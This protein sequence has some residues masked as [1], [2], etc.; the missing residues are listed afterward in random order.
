MRFCG[1]CGAPT[2]SIQPDASPKDAWTVG[3]GENAQVKIEHPSISRLHL[4]V[5]YTSDAEVLAITDLGT[6]N[7]TY[8]RSVRVSS[9]HVRL[10]DVIQLG[11][12][13][14]PVRNLLQSARSTAA[15]GTRTLT[16]GRDQGDIR[17]DLSVVSGRHAELRLAPG[18]LEIRD[19]GSSN[20]TYVD[21]IRVS[22]W[23]LVGANA[24]LHL[25]SFRVPPAQIERW[26]EQFTPAAGQQGVSNVSVALTKTTT[27]G[28]DPAS[29]VLI[30]HP[31]ISW[32]HARID[33]RGKTVNIVD[34]RSSNGV[35][36][37]G[38]RVT[39]ATISVGDAVR[40]GPVPISLQPDALVVPKAYRGEVRVDARGVTRQLESGAFAGQIILDDVSLTIFPGEMV[41]LMGPSGAGKT[42]LLEVLTGQRPPS[43]GTV[44]VNGLDLH[45]QRHTLADRIGYVPQEDVMHR[46][47]TVFEVLH[48]AARLRLPSDLP[49]SALREH[50]E[51]LIDRMG[52][53][54][55]RDTLIGGESV[56]GVSGGQRKRV[57]IALELL[58]EPPLL[59]LDEP[60]SGLDATS[61][62]EVLRVLRSLADEGKTIIM[63]I[64]QPRVEAFRMVDMLI[65]L[66]KGGKLAYFGPAVPGAVD[67][68]L[69]RSGNPHKADSNPADYA[70]DALDSIGAGTNQR[71]PD[72]KMEYRLSDQYREYVVTRADSQSH[73]A[74]HDAR[75]RRRTPF[76]Q[77]LTLVHRTL[78]RKSRESTALIVQALQP[79]I[80]GLLLAWIFTAT[81][82]NWPLDDSTAGTALA[83]LANQFTP[84]AQAANKVHAALFLVGACAFWLG[85]SNVAR[86]LVAERSVYRRERMSG[87]STLAYLSS[88]FFVQAALGL[89]QVIVLTF[90][91]WGFLPMESSVG[92]ALVVSWLTLVAGV[93]TGML[94]SATA[95]T[96]V[97][98]ISMLPLLLLPQLMLAGYLQLYRDLSSPLAALSAFMP[99]R[100]S[101]SALA[102]QEYSSANTVYSLQEAIGF[103]E[104]ALTAP[105]VLIGFTA[106]TLA[107]TYAKLRFTSSSTGT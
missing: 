69:R 19:L 57:N 94:V 12:L 56:R 26:R 70:L 10:D 64:H 14:V 11:L 80:V 24:P 31:A 15:I 98:A 92:S 30:D 52:L 71:T 90:L 82:I 75:D 29:T 77:T 51:R 101:F 63:T 91:V 49:D 6:A 96:E 17:V 106:L 9:A 66:A 38:Q 25:G 42:T 59:F 1:A 74:P 87:L 76:R 40:L 43:A 93:G 99:V 55:I 16:V 105:I 7:G 62:L 104:A 34:L 53:A 73:T 48:Y 3:S 86:E 37:N 67:Y 18:G 47:L 32:N 27:I 39:T 89:A 23:T 95:R 21:G 50:V 28:R 60:T 97:T 36:V 13:L 78:R 46:D 20:G 8:H 72:W 54:H 81:D 107:A 61:T 85:C 102:A 88:A 84:D 45:Q 79:A 41:A 35:F 83:S 65:L 68:F 100:W 103:P 33:V 58:T 4:T 22:G 44:L 2:G 5:A